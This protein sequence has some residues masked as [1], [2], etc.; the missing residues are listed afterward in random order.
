MLRPAH[1]TARLWRMLVSPVAAVQRLMAVGAGAARV[2]ALVRATNTV[3]AVLLL[4]LLQ[5][6]LPHRARRRLCPVQIIRLRA[7]HLSPQQPQHLLRWRQSRPGHPPALP[8]LA[9]NCTLQQLFRQL[10][11]RLQVL[12]LQVLPHSVP[13]VAEGHVRLPVPLLRRG[14]QL[15]L[16]VQRLMSAALRLLLQRFMSMQGQREP[17]GEGEGEAVAEAAAALQQ[18]QQLRRLRSPLQQRLR[19][20]GVSIIMMGRSAAQGVDAGVG[21]VEDVVAAT[22]QLPLQPAA[23]RRSRSAGRCDRASTLVKLVNASCI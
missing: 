16:P 14:L 20:Q 4:L 17:E 2:A 18:Q 21:V 12:R 9:T 8:A 13:V 6:R 11:L 5:L 10:L 19:R 22:P 15:Q 23:A 1:L 7:A 3:T